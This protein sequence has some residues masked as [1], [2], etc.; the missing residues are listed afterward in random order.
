M[1]EETARS[2]ELGL[3]DDEL[4]RDESGETE[5]ETETERGPVED[6]EEVAADARRRN[7]DR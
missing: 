1:H 6:R 7:P 3:A 5:T 2:H 4:M